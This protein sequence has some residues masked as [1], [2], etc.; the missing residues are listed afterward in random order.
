M[1]P[2][3]RLEPA[4]ARVPRRS[5]VLAVSHASGGAVR[6]RNTFRRHAGKTRHGSR[7]AR[8]HDSPRV[9]HVPL[10]R[11]TL[12]GAPQAAT[13]RLMP[14]S[15]QPSGFKRFVRPLVASLALA[16]GL[17]WVMKSGGLPLLPP[18]GSLSELEALPFVGFSIGMLFHLLI[19]FGRCQFLLAP[20]ARVPFWRVMVINGIAMALITFL[21]FRL[22]EV[23]RPAM[24]REKGKLSG[25]AVTGTVAAERILDG[26]VFSLMLLF[27]L[28]VAEPHLPLPTRIGDLPLSAALVPQAARIASV[29]FTLA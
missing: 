20:V 27:G 19:R 24:L 8:R 15:G 5:F 16:G 3:A 1:G 7:R 26:V 13:S 11:E 29:G 4:A 12:C 10:R 9:A 18:K 17:A 2:D 21:P 23:S 6:G 22:G 25:M 14:A 28:W